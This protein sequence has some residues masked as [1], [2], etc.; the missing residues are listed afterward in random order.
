MSL[1]VTETIAVLQVVVQT[2]PVGTN[3][4]LL[5]L[6]W[7]IMNGSFLASRGAIFPALQANGYTPATSQRIWQAFRYGVWRS[8]EC[9]NQWRAYVLSQEKWE[10]HCYEGYRPL[11]LDWTVVWRPKLKGWAGKWFHGL[12]GRALCGVGFGLVCNVG[13]IGEQ[14]VP[15]LRRMIRPR[16]ADKSNKQL[17]ADSLRWVTH[18]MAED[19][20]VIIDA[21]VEISDVQR[22]NIPRYVIRAALN[23]TARRNYLPD[24]KGRGRRPC[25]GEKVRPLPRTRLEKEIGATP[26]DKTAS[27]TLAQRTI[28]AQ[29]WVDVVSSNYKPSEAP[30]TFNLWV[31]FDPLYT[32]PLVLATNLGHA[33]AAT[34][35]SLYLDRW[36]VEQI[37][38]V[39]K[40]LLGLHRQ[41]VFAPESCYRLPELAFLLGNILTYLAASLPPLPTGFWDKRPR[42]TAGRLRRVLANANFPQDTLTD[43]RLRKKA[44]VTT[45]L[46]K[47]VAAHRRQKATT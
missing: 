25:W 14:R 34:I 45:H 9:V 39:A 4:A 8:D 6:M 21:G 38:L 17:K 18:H 11:A 24:Y 5:Q 31:F 47:G 10:S 42:R 30:A 40:Q 7:T 16:Q 36:P 43:P 26:P 23:C 32:T 2:V 19:E 20:V 1:A 27:F 33:Q 15:L 44:A 3:L 28:Q 29:G 13:R 37:P 12:A 41:F 35:F 22:A 46:P